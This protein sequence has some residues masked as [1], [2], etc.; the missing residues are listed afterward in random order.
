MV[1]PQGDPQG[2]PQ[3]ATTHS[4]RVVHIDVSNEILREPD[5]NT[6]DSSNNSD[7]H[8]S[9]NGDDDS[10]N[11]GDDPYDSSCVDEREHDR[12]HEHER[13]VRSP[14]T[15]CNRNATTLDSSY[16][17]TCLICMEPMVTRPRSA[18]AVDDLKP[19][20]RPSKK[21]RRMSSNDL[22]VALLH[23]SLRDPMEGCDV[24]LRTGCDCNYQAHQRCLN[25]WY[26]R[27]PS[28]PMC[29]RPA[30]DPNTRRVFIDARAR[31]SSG[32][33]TPP[34]RRFASGWYYDDRVDEDRRD[35]I[36][37]RRWSSGVCVCGSIF[38]IYILLNMFG[39]IHVPSFHP[40]NVTFA[41]S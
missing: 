19:P 39:A 5:D 14:S 13:N 33:T 40:S 24:T 3:E 16:S 11:D 30:F 17:N 21:R 34:M 29:R 25:E 26:S 37:R 32:A 12:E 27:D 10:S 7:A 2:D 38:A 4:T 20:R 41:F 18:D 8:T 36:D 22:H 9:S 31:R 1:D 28:C 35:A 23:D 15:N 6:D